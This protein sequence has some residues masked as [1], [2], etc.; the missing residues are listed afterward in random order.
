MLPWKGS[1]V[2]RLPR[3]RIS[4]VPPKEIIQMCYLCLQDFTFDLPVKP[5]LDQ[6]KKRLL[7]VK[8]LLNL[9]A[10]MSII[11]SL[12]VGNERTLCEEKVDE[13]KEEQY[14]LGREF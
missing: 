11:E 8:S 14:K 4:P 13:L 5:N 12:L 3:V 2:V 6:K 9:A 7:K 10:N 1:G